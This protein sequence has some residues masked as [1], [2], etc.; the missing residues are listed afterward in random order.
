MIEHGNTYTIK[1]ADGGKTKARVIQ[2]KTQ[3]R[4][5]T[6]RYKANGTE[7]SMSMTNFQKAMVA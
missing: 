1:T 5:H 4:G 7:H 3:G 6:V 2:I